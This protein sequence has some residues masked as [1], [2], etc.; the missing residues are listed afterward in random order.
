MKVAGAVLA[1]GLSRRMEG[2]EKSLLP[3]AGEPLIERVVSRLGAQ[4]EP[5]IINANGDHTRFDW[6]ALPVVED[7]IK[8]FAGPLAGVIASMRWAQRTTDISHILTVAAD[9]PFFPA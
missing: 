5:V 6:L 4:I 9:T 8:E 3:L 7:T 1:G 2:R